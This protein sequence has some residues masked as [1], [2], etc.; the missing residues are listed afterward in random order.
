MQKN[1]TLISNNK[2]NENTLLNAKYGLRLSPI[3]DKLKVYVIL[4]LR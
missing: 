2:C 3:V 4:S 1:I